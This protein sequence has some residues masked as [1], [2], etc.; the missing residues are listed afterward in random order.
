MSPPAAPSNIGPAPRSVKVVED[1][2]T[3]VV[4]VAAADAKANKAATNKAVRAGKN[5]FMR[6]AF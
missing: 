2:D 5:R 1:S 6:D 3:G 4:V